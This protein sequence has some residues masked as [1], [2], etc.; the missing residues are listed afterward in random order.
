MQAKKLERNRVW[1]PRTATQRLGRLL[2][3]AWIGHDRASMR[4]M[5]ELGLLLHGPVAGHA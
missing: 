5:S 3:T 4:E 1:T 2:D